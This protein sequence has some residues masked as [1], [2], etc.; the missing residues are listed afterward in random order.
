MS[1]PSNKTMILE[2]GKLLASVILAYFAYAT[3][4]ATS[5]TEGDSGYKALAQSVKELQSVVEVQ[6][7]EIAKLQGHLEAWEEMPS[8]PVGPKKIR[9]RKRGLMDNLLP[10]FMIYDQPVAAVPTRPECM[11]DLDC[12]PGK[13]CDSGKCVANP[14]AVPAVAAELKPKFS[15]L[16]DNPAAAAAE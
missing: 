6:G 10:S 14:T 4:V 11:F 2:V 1:K 9:E 8:A 16:P 15:P 7:R 13:H 5:K 3:A 12:K